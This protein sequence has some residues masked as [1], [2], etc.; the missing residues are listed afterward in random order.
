MKVRVKVKVKGKVKDF[1]RKE[2]CKMENVKCK[3]AESRQWRDTTS[4]R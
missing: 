1:G 2:E 4:L 3:M